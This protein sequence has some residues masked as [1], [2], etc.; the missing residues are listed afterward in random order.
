MCGLCGTFGAADHWAD[1]LAA[2]ASSPLAE[3]RRRAAVANRIL[4]CYG[5]KL[6]QWANRFTL[7]SNTGK[8]TVVDNFG[9][10]WVEAEKIL[11]RSCDPLDL[12]V[13]AKMEAAQHGH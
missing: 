5:L 8:A 1:G 10:L 11:G 9:S 13:I 3:R 4:V 6:T 2:G 12:E 7:V